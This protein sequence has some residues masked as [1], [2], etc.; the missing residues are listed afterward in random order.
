MESDDYL[1][2]CNEQDKEKYSLDMVKARTFTYVADPKV[3]GSLFTSPVFKGS[4]S[5][6]KQVGSIITTLLKKDSASFNDVVVDEEFA[7]AENAVKTNM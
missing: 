6:R 3:A 7:K 4:D 2:I 5:A 1:D